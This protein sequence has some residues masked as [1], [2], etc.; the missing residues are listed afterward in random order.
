MSLCPFFSK[1]W[2]SCLG[3]KLLMYDMCDLDE[4][5]VS[6]QCVVHFGRSAVAV[7][8]FL[9]FPALPQPRLRT[10]NR[11]TSHRAAPAAAA[12]RHATPSHTQ[13]QTFTPLACFVQREQGGPR[14]DCVCVFASSFLTL[15]NAFCPSLTLAS[16]FISSSFSNF[17][18]ISRS[19]SFLANPISLPLSLP[20]RVTWLPALANLVGMSTTLWCCTTTTALAGRSR[21]SCPSRWT[22]FG[23]RTCGSSSDTAPVS[24]DGDFF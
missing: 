5:S 22:C 7:F 10:E 16:R 2:M 18:S 1:Q 14:R 17:S 15:N 21:S 11:I 20:C 6:L 13:A 12:T 23:D 19:R 3:T 9:W 8:L 4:S 24:G